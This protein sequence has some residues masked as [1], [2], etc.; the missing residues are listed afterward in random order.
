MNPSVSIIVPVYNAE[1][2]I[3]RC[4][5]SILHQSCGDFELLVVDD[6]SP[7]S[8]GAICDAYAA[9]D[10]RV[11]VFHKENGGVS[12]ARNLALEQARGKYI[13]FLDSDDW[14]TPDATLLLLRAAEEHEADLV[15]SDFYRVVGER[16]SVKG[17]I[18]EGSVLTQEEYAAHMM[19]NPADFYYGV[20][21]NKLYRRSIVERY[22]L[23]MD[24]EI[25]WCEDFLFNLEYIR[26]A[27]RFYALNVPIYYYVKTKGSLASQIS[28][29]KTVRMKLTMFEYYNRLYK[30]IFDEEEYEKHRLKVYRFLLDAAGDGSVPP[31]ILPNAKKLG[32]ER[33]R[34]QPETLAEEGVMAD[35]Y[36]ERKLLERCLEPAA[37]EHD[38]TLK[39]ALVLLALG[40]DG[41][42]GSRK[43]LAALA[44]VSLSSLYRA[45]QQLGAKGF[46]RSGKERLTVM[47][48][49]EE[50]MTA[51][52][53]TI[54]DWK[55]LRLADFTQEEEEAYKALHRRVRQNVR[56]ALQ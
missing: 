23:R 55:S 32:D 17:D 20:L 19:E 39:E 16:V 36:R 34:V 33:V 15:I 47:E 51:L 44:G 41:F 7:D 13:Q 48:E 38:L 12:A 37:L 2:T 25:S 24:E 21:W 50:T 1:K 27:R 18:E 6:G 45:L 46:V 30:E 43:D 5:E 40:R 10:A 11:R 4:I 8:S 29:S 56:K 54:A 53:A 28:I 42:S 3:R 22:R 35:A 31:A 52:E 9:G 26:C 49:A 14:I